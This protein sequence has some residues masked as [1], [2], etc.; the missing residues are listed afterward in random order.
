MAECALLYNAALQERRDAWTMKGEAVTFIDQCKS[1]VQVRADLPEWSALDTQVGRGVLRRVDRAFTAFF[2]RCKR[3]E[4]PGFPRFKPASRFRTLEIAEPRPG[5]L[6]VRPDS[7]KAY[8]KIKGLPTIEIRLKREL[9]ASACLKS[10]RICRRPTG[11]VIDLGY[12]VERE[13]FPSVGARVGIDLG[14][15]NRIALSNGEM[16]EGHRFKRDREV[17]L[18]QAVSR[19]RRGSNRRRKR[20]KMLSRETYRNQV[21]NRNAV[22]ALTTGLVRDYSQ[23]AIERLQIRNMTRSAR[24]TLEDPGVNVRAKSGLNREILNQTWGLIREQ[25]RYKAAWAG[26]EFVEVPPEFTSRI[27]H[28][29]GNKT[30]QGEY[31]TY[32]CGVCGGEWDRDTNAARNVLQR[33]FGPSTGAGIPPESQ[34]VEVG[35]TAVL[36]TG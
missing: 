3:G 24:G 6:K 31:R 5:M 8:V 7:K 17:R 23:I 25:L 32:R 21:R 4:T 34:E 28:A 16:V 2:R 35:T 22:H 19:S 10:L 27:C 20:V 30:P 11:L 12:R 14:V 18:R 26:R 13:P 15:N 33:A 9:P 1:L 29:C 36:A